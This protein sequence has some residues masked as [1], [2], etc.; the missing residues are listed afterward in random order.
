M[1]RFLLLFILLMISAIGCSTSL[2]EYSPEQVIQNALSEKHTTAEYYAESTWIMKEKGEVVESLTIKEWQNEDGK[3]RVETKSK[4]DTEHSIAIN[5]GKSLITYIPDEKKA[6]VIES[7]ELT[8]LN[9]QSPKEQAEQLLKL[10]QDTHEIEVNGEEKVAERDTFHLKATAKEDRSLIG[11]Q[12]IWIDKE[13]WFVLKMISTSGETTIEWEYTKI[14]YKVQNDEEL[15]TIQLPDDVVVENLDDSFAG[16][17]I[18][19]EQAK[20][21]LD[22]SFL[23]IPE[24]E[25][26]K[27]AYVELSELGGEINRKEITIEYEKAGLPY[28]SFTVFQ[29]SSEQSDDITLSNEEDIQIR[30]LDGTWSEEL[31]WLQWVEKGMTYSITVKD[32]NVS[33]EELRQLLEKMVSF[34]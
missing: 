7:E 13:T 5:N 24:T 6:F 23:Y 26:L 22:A 19:F 31:R 14:D 34:D 32:P 17:E 12:D 11:N 10:I 1:K 33:L 4:N 2:Q 21:E 3:K 16:K 20:E 9:Q 18:T 15:F 25:D 30:G 27:I 8:S 28:L 29:H